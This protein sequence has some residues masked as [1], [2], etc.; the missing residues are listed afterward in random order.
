LIKGSRIV[1]IIA[2][3]LLILAGIIALVIRYRRNQT[4]I[5][6]RIPD[7][8][9]VIVIISGIILLIGAIVSF[10]TKSEIGSKSASRSKKKLLPPVILG[11]IIVPPGVK[12]KRQYVCGQ[13]LK[14][15]LPGHTFIEDYRPDWL[16]NPRTGRNLEL[17]FYCEE[18]KLGLEHD[19]EQHEKYVPRYH[20]GGPSDL[21]YQKWKDK[22]KRDICK[23]RGVSV[24]TVSYKVKDIEGYIVEEL[25]RL[26]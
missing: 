20:L 6:K 3:F 21:E 14:R 19:G 10:L 1:I 15:H 8:Y 9:S 24:I 23:V 12:Y 5:R 26:L 16:K 22:Y 7:V 4:E 11:P 2:G 18:L 17:D 13:V 25:K